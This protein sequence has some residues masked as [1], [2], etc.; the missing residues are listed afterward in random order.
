MHITNLNLTNYVS[1]RNV[2]YINDV[3][4]INDF[5]SPLYKNNKGFNTLA[6]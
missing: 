2:S 1:Y 5:N 3:K 4:D 6:Q